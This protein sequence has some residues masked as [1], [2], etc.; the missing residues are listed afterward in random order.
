MNASEA[1]NKIY[2]LTYI[3]YLK[4]ANYPE[5]SVIGSG[6]VVD[7]V[8]DNGIIYLIGETGKDDPFALGYAQAVADMKKSIQDEF[9]K[10]IEDMMFKPEPKRYDF[11]KDYHGQFKKKDEEV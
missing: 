4:E 9:T 1:A 8:I 3:H 10:Y 2:Q 5:V 11:K 7:I 6:K